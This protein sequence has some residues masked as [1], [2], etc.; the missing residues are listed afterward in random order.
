MP[1]QQSEIREG[2]E[3][4]LRPENTEFMERMHMLMSRDAVY[5]TFFGASA[6][7]ETRRLLWIGNMYVEGETD[8]LEILKE[9]IRVYASRKA[10]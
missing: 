2:A 1:L 10:A 7:L 5:L 8:A 6:A 3:I 9:A 4:L